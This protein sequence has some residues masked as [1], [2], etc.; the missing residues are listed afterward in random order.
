L[1]DDPVA[2]D[3]AAE[4]LERYM[5]EPQGLRAWVSEVPAAMKTQRVGDGVPLSADLSRLDIEMFAPAWLQRQ[6]LFL[7][8]LYHTLMINLHRPFI[9]F[10]AASVP[11]PPPKPGPLVMAHAMT[12]VRHAIAL[13]TLL[14]QVIV[15]TDLLDGWHE[16]FQQQWNASITMVGS[17][18]AFPADPVASDARA[19]VGAAIEV[20]EA[21]GRQF[22]VGTS[23]ANAT[24]ELLSKADLLRGASTGLGLAPQLEAVGKGTHH[25][26][27][28]PEGDEANTAAPPGRTGLAATAV[29]PSTGPEVGYQ[30]AAFLPEMTDEEA[31]A[32]RDM[33]AD[34]MDMVYSADSFQPMGVPFPG[35]LNMAMD[36]W[37]P[38][39]Y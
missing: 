23:A 8:L 5:G 9:V 14:R 25:Q 36:A 30:P 31:A 21:F 13:T 29:A 12:A 37:P 4:V 28:G 39:F 18:L 17:V 1:Y 15:E 10:P 20:F 26:R 3:T 35:G 27:G 16:A 34:T 24:R 38:G 7:E 6:R 19:A 2:L 11:S 33:L 32:V 22:S